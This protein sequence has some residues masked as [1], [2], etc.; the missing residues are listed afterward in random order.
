[1]KQIVKLV[2]N[3]AYNLRLERSYL[4]DRFLWLPPS[5]WPADRPMLSSSFDVDFGEPTPSSFAKMVKVVPPDP[6]V[7]QQLLLTSVWMKDKTQCSPAEVKRITYYSPQDVSLGQFL[8]DSCFN[9]SLR[10]QNQKC[11]RPMLDHCMSFCHRGK[12]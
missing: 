9:V 2:V 3:V 7:H 6:V 8:M 1:M 4:S 12:E 10:C 5:T 11:Q